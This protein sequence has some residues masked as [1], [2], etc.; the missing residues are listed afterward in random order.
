MH[1]NQSLQLFDA[2]IQRGHSYFLSPNQKKAQAMQTVLQKTRADQIITAQMETAEMSK[3][4]LISIGAELCIHL[5]STCKHSYQEYEKTIIQEALN[6]TKWAKLYRPEMSCHWE[7]AGIDSDFTLQ[8][9]ASNDANLQCEI[10]YRMD[11]RNQGMS[12]LWGAFEQNPENVFEDIVRNSESIRKNGVFVGETKEQLE[13]NK[14]L[15]Q[16][17]KEG[18]NNQKMSKENLTS[19]ADRYLAMSIMNNLDVM[20]RSGFAQVVSKDFDP[21]DD[22]AEYQDIFFENLNTAYRLVTKVN[23]IRIR[24]AR[25][26]MEEMHND[27]ATEAVRYPINEKNAEMNQALLED[28][29]D[30]RTSLAIATDSTRSSS[31]ELELFEP[32]HGDLENIHEKY[33]TFLEI[34]EEIINKK[35]TDHNLHIVTHKDEQRDLT[36][37]M[38]KKSLQRYAIWAAGKSEL[39]LE[40]LNDT[41]MKTNSVIWL[42]S[43]PDMFVDASRPIQF[44]ESIIEG[45]II[46]KRYLE[47]Y[48]YDSMKADVNIL[49]KKSTE[50]Y[51]LRETESTPTVPQ[52]ET[53]LSVLEW[54]EMDHSMQSYEKSDFCLKLVTTD[55]HFLHDIVYHVNTAINETKLQKAEEN[56]RNPITSQKDVSGNK[57]SLTEAV[58]QFLS[59]LDLSW[60]TD[61]RQL[62][63][64]F[65]SFPGINWREYIFSAYGVI[66]DQLTLLNLFKVTGVMYLFEYVVYKIGYIPVRV[67]SMFLNTVGKILLKGTSIT[68]AACR[69][70]AYKLWMQVLKIPEMY[71]KGALRPAIN[72]DR[73][74][75]S[76]EDITEDVTT[77]E[78]D[79][80]VQD[81]LAFL[82]ESGY[83]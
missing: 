31:T 10:S 7:H 49:M 55:I 40:F 23:Q 75:N 80:D 58:N 37:E 62:Y 39:K 51:A 82:K 50:Y 54:P 57:L 6:S 79:K 44:R 73:P 36:K 9:P 68:T 74:E 46:L 81:L 1:Y 4:Q 43:N 5:N 41:I 34:T 77:Q 60:M 21:E 22:T 63:A 47:R 65:P 35:M 26:A 13:N 33:P 11:P 29:Q 19:E 52:N 8:W 53:D 2:I 28:D 15:E 20:I 59:N 12:S 61:L 42:A 3:G 70:F 14:F 67:L 38:I 27:I 71:R 32:R 17:T 48:F 18:R 78:R 45:E 30:T 66:I 24:G 69:P 25:K 16:L 72:D 83:D 56:S 76:T 64:H